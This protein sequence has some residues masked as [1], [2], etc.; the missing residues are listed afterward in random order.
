ME[1]LVQIKNG[2]NWVNAEKSDKI[3]LGETIRIVDVDKSEEEDGR[4]VRGEF[5][6]DREIGISDLIQS[7]DKLADG[8]DKLIAEA[9]Q[10][11]AARKAKEAEEAKKAKE[12]E[13]AKK[14]SDKM[15]KNIKH[16]ASY[17]RN[18]IFKAM[19]AFAAATYA[20]Q[21]ATP[22]FAMGVVANGPAF[23]VGNLPVAQALLAF[24]AV[25]AGLVVLNK[26][27]ET[28]QAIS[29]RV[30]VSK[31][32]SVA[33]VA[34]LT[35]LFASDMRITAAV[36]FATGICAYAKQANKLVKGMDSKEWSE[37][38]KSVV[39]KAAFPAFAVALSNNCSNIGQF[40]A[41]VL[42]AA[43]ATNPVLAAVTQAGVVAGAAGVVQYATQYFGG[44]VYEDVSEK[45]R[46]SFETKCGQTVNDYMP[47]ISTIATSVAYGYAAKVAVKA[48][49]DNVYVQIASSV[50]A[51]ALASAPQIKETFAPAPAPAI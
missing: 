1:F 22:A 20:Y 19:P 6:A 12:A 44:S 50:I 10:A 7:G 46:R 15:I 16:G 2:E 17:V 29:K 11:E 43:S 32:A 31:A 38:Y 23:I 42:T 24:T 48:V 18:F 34:V 49:S 3:Q 9:M 25:G 37:L 26:Y 13:E 5:V 21:S 36:T 27:G 28:P 8:V 47:A 39:S 45:V 14:A 30:D 41:P 33:S 51:A 40:I 4:V 35:H